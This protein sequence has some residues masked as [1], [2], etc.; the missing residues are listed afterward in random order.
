MMS[1]TDEPVVEISVEDDGMLRVKVDR[2][3]LE[4]RSARISV[5]DLRAKLD[6]VAPRDE[7]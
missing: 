5:E 2:P 3:G 6:A 4:A 7:V 1:D